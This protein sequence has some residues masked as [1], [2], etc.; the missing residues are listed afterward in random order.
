MKN[1]FVYL[2]TVALMAGGMAFAQSNSGQGTTTQGTSNQGA[3]VPQ[4]TTPAPQTG[5]HTDAQGDLPG[6]KEGE[7]QS[8]EAST[9]NPKE[10]R[11]GA[12]GTPSTPGQGTSPKGDL[13]ATG[14]QDPQHGTTDENGT[15]PAVDPETP[16]PPTGSGATTP[17]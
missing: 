2:A 10:E 6:V 4:A 13:P 5:G 3:T 15:L 12:M 1:K 14:M 16:P 17:K 8:G 7:T 11:P 9:A